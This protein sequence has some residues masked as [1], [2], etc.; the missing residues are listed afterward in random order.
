VDDGCGILPEDLPLAF[1]SHALAARPQ[2]PSSLR[3][4]ARTRPSTPPP[5]RGSARPGLPVP[6]C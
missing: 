2:A 3:P 1:A 6:P 4:P 5:A